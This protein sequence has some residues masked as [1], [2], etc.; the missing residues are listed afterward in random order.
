MS[1]STISPK[2]DLETLANWGTACLT[3]VIAIDSQSD[4]ESDDIPSSQGQRVLSDDLR[5]FFSELGYGA[6]QDDAANLIITIP[7]NL[8]ADAACPPVALMVHMDTAQGTLAVPALE[9][10]P[11]WD[12]SRV[13]YPENP[14]LTVTAERYPDV[15]CF[16]GDD[17]LHGPGSFPIG[18]DDKLGMAE[19]MTLARVLS[20]NPEIAHGTL[21][22]VFRPDEEIGR[23]AAVEGLAD[24]LARRGVRYGYTID[25]LLPFEINVENFNAAY[26]RAVIAE[27]A[28]AAGDAAAGDAAADDSVEF[29]RLSVHGVNTHGATAKPEGHLNATMVAAR[30]LAAL[31]ARDDIAI[32][33]MQSD[34][35]L[36]CDAALVFA[37]RGA[38]AE[39]RERAASALRE[40]FAAE[41]EPHAWKGA[42]LDSASV[43]APAAGAGVGNGANAAA[44]VIAHLQGLLREP[45]PTPLLPEESDGYE[46]Y[47]NPFFVAREGGALVLEYRLRDFDPARLERRVAHVRAL[48]E[49]DGFAVESK[50]QYID[51]GPKL[52]AYPE[53]VRWAEQALQTI[54]Q[55]VLRRPIRGGTGVDPFL[56]RDIPVANLG[57]GYFAPESEKEF[58]SRQN[59]ARHALWLVHLVQVI[60]AD[61]AETAKPASS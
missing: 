42:H 59:I 2:Q 39:A 50:N 30:A 13:P 16:V 22:L 8:G 55:P 31:G 29:V 28:P 20:E 40:A 34:P 32:V 14:R 45:G 11:G 33:D 41:I 10:L 46:G 47:T 54:S 53:L 51:M 36:E 60:A 15:A 19:L 18:L 27:T 48:C 17:L 4:E 25:G 24:E 26:A 38:D 56:E 52:A 58:T 6:E 37:V 21:V 49:R 35:A 1:Q 43:A 23:M 5:R 57:T 61:P 7:S 44:R 9:V 3:R 12:G